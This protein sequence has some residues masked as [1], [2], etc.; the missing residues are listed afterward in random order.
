[1][2][3]RAAQCVYRGGYVCDP[4]QEKGCYGKGLFGSGQQGHQVIRKIQLYSKV[5]DLQL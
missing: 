1:H 2:W 3:C 4:R 5:H